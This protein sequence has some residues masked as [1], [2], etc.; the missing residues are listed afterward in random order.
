MDGRARWR[1]AEEFWQ[2]EVGEC[3]PSGS[4]VEGF[5]TGALE[6]YDQI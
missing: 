2:V 6:V 1:E 3:H 4:F 5:V